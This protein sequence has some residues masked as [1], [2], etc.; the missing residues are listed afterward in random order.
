MAFD[1]IDSLNTL[2]TEEYHK[3]IAHH[4]KLSTMYFKYTNKLLT[5]ESIAYKFFNIIDFLTQNC[6]WTWAQ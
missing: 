4:K 3:C 6:H 2:M 1:D 5:F